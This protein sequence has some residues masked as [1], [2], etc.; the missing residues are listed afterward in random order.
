MGLVPEVRDIE[1]ADSNVAETNL[2]KEVEESDINHKINVINLD[3]V[4]Q[5]IKSDTLVISEE[6]YSSKDNLESGDLKENDAEI[7][8]RT[9]ADDIVELLSK[10]IKDVQEEIAG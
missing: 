1:I 10:S 7:V 4:T 9:E 2:A 8:E 5:D 6:P 3:E